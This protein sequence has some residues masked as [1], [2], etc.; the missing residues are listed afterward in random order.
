MMSPP[1][2][3]PPM[4]HRIPAVV[5]VVVI[6]NLITG[7][8]V[9]RAR[10]ALN[11]SFSHFCHNGIN[12]MECGAYILLIK[13]RRFMSTSP[14]ANHQPGEAKNNEMVKNCIVVRQ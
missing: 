3:G 7:P 12:K 4:A 6:V 11:I 10:R 13:L 9:K 5:V 14:P 8:E 1:I 2:H